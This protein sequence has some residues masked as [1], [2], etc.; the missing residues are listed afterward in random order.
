MKH[1]SHHFIIQMIKT[2]QYFTLLNL[3]SQFVFLYPKYALDFK[4]EE[5]KKETVCG[6][7]S[8]HSV[9]SIQLF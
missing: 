1:D 9:I 5:M 4:E 8:I 7:N 6:Q 2:R 3:K